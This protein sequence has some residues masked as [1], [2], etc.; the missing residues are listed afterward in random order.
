MT[1]H[2]QRREPITGLNLPAARWSVQRDVDH[3]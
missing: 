2:T 1:Q 3:D